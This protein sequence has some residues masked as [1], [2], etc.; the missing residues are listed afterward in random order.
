MADDMAFSITLTMWLKERL[1]EAEQN[2]IVDC[3]KDCVRMESESATPG[4]VKVHTVDVETEE[5][6]TEAEFAKLR[7]R[8]PRLS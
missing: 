8:D 2:T 1:T 4:F 6:V 3:L 7:E 5:D